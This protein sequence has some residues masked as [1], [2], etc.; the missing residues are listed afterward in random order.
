MRRGRTVSG[1]LLRRSCFSRRLGE[2]CFVQFGIAF[3]PLSQRRTAASCRC[4]GRSHGQTGT[5]MISSGFAHLSDTG[6]PPDCPS[7]YRLAIRNQNVLAGLH[8][9]NTQDSIL[10]SAFV[11]SVNGPT[12]YHTRSRNTHLPM[13]CPRPRHRSNG[14]FPSDPSVSRFSNVVAC[15]I[16]R[17]TVFVSSGICIWQLNSGSFLSVLT[18]PPASHCSLGQT[19]SSVITGAGVSKVVAEPALLAYLIAAATCITAPSTSHLSAAS[20]LH[21]G[22]QPPL[23]QRGVQRPFLFVDPSRPTSVWHLRSDTHNQAHKWILIIVP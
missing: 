20:Q 4:P 2:G 15:P 5:L 7:N 1:T 18:M 8:P 10:S 23:S 6:F 13:W 16:I 21:A 17:A 12:R 22:P 19:I 14:T 3:T 11:R 9:E